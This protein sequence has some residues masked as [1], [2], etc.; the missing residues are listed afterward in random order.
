MKLQHRLDRLEGALAA[1][2]N[3]DAAA[4]FAALVATLDRMAA[5][6]AAGCATVQ[7]DLAALV[8]SLDGGENGGAAKAT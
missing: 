3:P 8:A 6:K 4:T 5:R 1:R 7:R 2:P